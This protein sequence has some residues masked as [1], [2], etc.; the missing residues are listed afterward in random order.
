MYANIHIYIIIIYNIGYIGNTII[1]L[2]INAFTFPGEKNACTY[3]KDMLCVAG[4][5]QRII[6]IKKVTK[7][8]KNATLKPDNWLT[9]SCIITYISIWWNLFFNFVLCSIQ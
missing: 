3:R 2:L 8:C 7:E 1:C 9:L 4:V 6:I 5:W